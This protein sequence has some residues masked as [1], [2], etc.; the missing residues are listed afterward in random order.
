M[1]TPDLKTGSLQRNGDLFSNVEQ[2][3]CRW[4]W[5][6]V[7]SRAALPILVMYVLF[8]FL[9]CSFT[10]QSRATVLETYWQNHYRTQGFCLRILASVPGRVRQLN[11]GI[12][13][14]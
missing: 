6:S 2:W 1:I 9:T 12:G 11:D 5:L 13:K 14:T 4:S 3:S 8:K 7:Y 10:Q